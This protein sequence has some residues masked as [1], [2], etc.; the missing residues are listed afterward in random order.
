MLAEIE[1]KKGSSA[2]VIIQDYLKA[3]ELE[4]Q[5]AAA[6]NNL[7]DVLASRKSKYDDALFWAQKALAQKP[8]SPIVE[9]TIGWIYYREGKY[10][11]ALPYLEKSAKQMDRPVAHY[12]LAGVLAKSGD[13]GREP[14]STTWR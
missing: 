2:D 9:D 12:H 7:A 13:P 1:T 10:G 14:Q 8:N 6:M 11:D 3:L 5:N 4:P